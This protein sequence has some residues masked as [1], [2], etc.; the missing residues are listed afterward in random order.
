VVIT[1]GL[2]SCPAANACGGLSSFSAELNGGLAVAASLALVADFDGKV[3]RAV[4]FFAA[5]LRLL[6]LLPAMMRLNFLILLFHH[7]Q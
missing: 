1:T 7:L 4:V 3:L 6:V 5:G 2:G